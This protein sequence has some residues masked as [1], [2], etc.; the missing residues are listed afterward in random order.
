MEEVMD[1]V[2]KFEKQEVITRVMPVIVSREDF[3]NR[4][5]YLDEETDLLSASLAPKPHLKLVE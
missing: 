5:S 2:I 1:N 3:N 4:E